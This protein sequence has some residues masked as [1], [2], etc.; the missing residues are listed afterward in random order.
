MEISKYS[1]DPEADIGELLVPDCGEAAGFQGERG[2]DNF[3]GFESFGVLL[4]DRGGGCA[5]V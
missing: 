4:Y 2:K 5:G 1:E 3:I